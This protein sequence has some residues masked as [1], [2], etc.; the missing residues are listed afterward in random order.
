MEQLPCG[1][2]EK[3][4]TSNEDYNYDYSNEYS[5][6]S[7]YYSSSSTSNVSRSAYISSDPNTKSLSR[8]THLP[9]VE[10]C[11]C[12]T[13]ANYR[14]VKTTPTT[15]TI[16]T[17]TITTTTI[18]TTTTAI[19]TATESNNAQILSRPVKPTKMVHDSG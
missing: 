16:T 4:L 3:N 12:K 18:T 14:L 7:S 19:S 17:T 11:Q 5:S 6:S 15:T 8:K 1:Q 10:I 9:G 2:C 13:D